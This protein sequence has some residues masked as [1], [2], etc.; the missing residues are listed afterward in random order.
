MMVAASAIATCDNTKEG[1][2]VAEMDKTMTDQNETAK[3]GEPG[4]RLRAD[5]LGAFKL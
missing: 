3:H 2:N 4:N 1:Q 5:Q